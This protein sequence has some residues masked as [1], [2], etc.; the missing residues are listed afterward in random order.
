MGEKGN[1]P[2]GLAASVMGSVEPSVI[3]KV[4]T[5][6]TQTIMGAGEDVLT[7]VRDKAVDHGADAIFEGGRERIRGKASANADAS[8]PGGSEP[9]LEGTDEGAEGATPLR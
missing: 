2:S 8:E 5:T 4:T 7:K 9:D 1:D 6:T 3:E